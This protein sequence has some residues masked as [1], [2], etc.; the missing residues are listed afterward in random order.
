MDAAC[1][2]ERAAMMDCVKS[3]MKAKAA[4]GQNSMNYHLQRLARMIRK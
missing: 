1:L 2:G 4:G 3:S